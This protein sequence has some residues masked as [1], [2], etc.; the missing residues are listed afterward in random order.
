MCACVRASVHASERACE[1]ACERASERAIE[2]ACV[3]ACV[4]GHVDGSGSGHDHVDYHGD[5]GGVGHSSVGAHGKDD[6]D[7]RSGLERVD[8]I[9]ALALIRH[10]WDSCNIS[11]FRCRAERPVLPFAIS[12]ATTQTY[13][14]SHHAQNESGPIPPNVVPTATTN[15]RSPYSSFE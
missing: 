3:R 1:R 4:H 15:C 9:C 11:D 10:A 6:R 12:L 7:H 14:P 8:T 13:A 5:G 2:R